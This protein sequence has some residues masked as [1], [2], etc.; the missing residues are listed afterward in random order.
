MKINKILI[1]VASLLLVSACTTKKDTQTETETDTKDTSEVIDYKDERDFT[2]VN[3]LDLPSSTV[4]NTS[5][6]KSI[7]DY[8]AFYKDVESFD[9]E[10]ASDYTY[11][12]P[13]H[14]AYNEG[15]YLYWNTELVNGVMGIAIN[16]KNTTT[17]TVSFEFYQNATI[18]A[19]PTTTMV[20]DLAYVEPISNRSADYNNF[21]TEDQN[22]KAIDVS[23][24]QQLWYAAEHGYRIN[25][26]KD[27]P[28]EKY[29]NQAKDLLRSIIKDDMTD[30]Q[31]VDTIYNYIEHHASYCFEALD[32]PESEDVTNYPD[33]VCAKY[34]AFFIEGFFDNKTVVCDGYSKV[35]TLLGR[36]E[37]L[38]VVRGAGSKDDR[39]ITKE[40][41]GHAYCY[42][43]LDGKYY[44]SCPTWGQQRVSLN[45]FV[46]T[47]SYFL[48]PR[49]VMDKE[50]P[51][52]YWL[53]Y[54]YASVE[55]CKPAFIN[56]NFKM[57]DNTYPTYITS[58]VDTKPIINGLAKLLAG[59]IE[60]AVEFYFETKE[61][62]NVFLQECG[63]KYYLNVLNDGEYT[64]VIY[65]Y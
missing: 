10:I 40:V 4:H 60:Y 14:K 5:E 45:K 57:E 1:L 50:Y 56:R 44:L 23:T 13:T 51:C 63:S 26:S 54:D 2:Y 38:N 29:Y 12:A 46:V 9:V 21:A 58:E 52:T 6:L 43:E 20:K 11:S 49:A 17:W 7:I 36:M 30:Y 8:H 28:A 35:Y 48:A 31:K 33:R 55:N 64:G 27:S 25:A 16:E 47:S 32:A 62:K 61:T 41:A 19:K 22:K 34:K 3:K 53:D 39:C 37:G 65:N 24:T 42:V 59:N 15:C 18:N